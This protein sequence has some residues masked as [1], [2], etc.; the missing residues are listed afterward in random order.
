MYKWQFC[1][2]GESYQMP[3]VKKWKFKFTVPLRFDILVR[4]EFLQIT[5]FRLFFSF[6]LSVFPAARSYVICL[7]VRLSVRL[8]DSLPARL[9]V[10]LS[11]CMN[12]C[13]LTVCLKWIFAESLLFIGTFVLWPITICNTGCSL[14][15]VFFFKILYFFLNSASS[16]SVLVFYLPGVCTH[17]NNK[18]KQSPEYS[19]FFE[20]NTIFN[21][22]PVVT[23]TLGGVHLFVTTLRKRPKDIIVEWKGDKGRGPVGIIF[24][25]FKYDTVSNLGNNTGIFRSVLTILLAAQC[26]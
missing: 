13:L 19:K 2:H 15:I 3:V 26:N 17:T 24:I 20:Q 21:E 9:S 12:K 5:Y 14:D 4:R 22:H 16:A 11:M 10:H 6:S 8:S 18:R 23:L 7:Y 1:Q 25:I